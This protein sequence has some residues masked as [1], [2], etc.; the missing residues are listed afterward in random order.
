MSFKDLEI[1]IKYSSINNDIINDFYVPTL[2]KSKKYDRAVGYFSSAALLGYI[3][4][5]RKF[6]LNDGVMR[7][8]IS[9]VLTIEDLNAVIESRENL[10]KITEN[11][12]EN[13]LI[14]E[15]SIKSSQILF[16]LLKKGVLEIKIAEPVNEKGIFH[17]K[18]GIF[19]DN[20]GNKISMIGSNNETLSALKLNTESFM[21]FKSW[22]KLGNMYVEENIKDFEN[23]WENKMNNVKFTNIN[24]ILPADFLNKFKTNDSIDELFDSILDEDKIPNRFKP[25]DYQIEAAERWLIDKRGILEMATGTGK[26]KTAIYINNILRTSCNK[27][28]TI[29][30][31]PD[32]TLLNQW[33][34]EMKDEYSK[35]LKCYS[36]NPGWEIQLKDEIGLYKY[37]EKQQSLVLVTI[38]SFYSDKFRRQ[39]D[40]FKGDYF[41][42]AD[43]MHRF[44][45]YNKVRSLP[46]PNMILG[47]SATPEVYGN[48]ELTRVLY[49]F[50]GGVIFKYDLEK[51]IK[52]RY[53]VNYSYHPIIVDL[54]DSEVESY[55]EITHK[56]V[57]MIGSD[58]DVEFSND[59]I[60]S[61]LLFKR[62]RV[63]YGAMNKLVILDNIIDEIEKKGNLVIYSGITSEKEVEIN[64]TLK[65][66][67][68]R[69]QDKQ[70]DEIF[71]KQIDSVGKILSKRNIRFSRYTSKESEEERI[72]SIKAFKDKTYSTLLAI[73]C[74]DE[75]VD[76]P[77][78]ERAIIMASS[79]NPREFIQRRG[80]ILRKH[81]DENG[82]AKEK[83]EIYDF[84]VLQENDNN[85]DFTS[86][87]R[88]ELQRF[89]EF[90]QLA[91]N[92]DELNYKL[93]RFEKLYL[94][95][96]V[97]VYD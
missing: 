57:K 31:L 71:M 16:Y 48:K 7:L 1:T 21:I 79:T 36:K 87:N 49:D 17:D 27:L 59:P 51:A 20:N 61:S 85:T 84:I 43:E 11:M 86:L 77:S 42:I 89:Y 6:V 93:E 23:Y 12:F 62:A 45:T 83:A 55:K 25:R 26:T 72:S 75:G 63:I 35:I 28:F 41:L 74:L 9:P 33:G 58:E 18:I 97:K 96:G 46:N 56:I 66:D 4:G 40:K 65:N 10:T 92:K 94:R 82:K 70:E 90:S 73:R 30:V 76:I 24:E 54:T 13:F 64:Q 69:Y 3:Q 29:V 2:N 68:L 39:L 53:L 32:I 78:I 44:G 22:D 80:R 50:F 52:N 34:N 8:I 37:S 81:Y 47:L 91:E 14:D 19:Y 38:Q 5:L 95:E 15:G 60:I 67:D 88:K